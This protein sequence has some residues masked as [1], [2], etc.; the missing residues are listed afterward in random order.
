MKNYHI[1]DIT[2]LNMGLSEFSFYLFG[3]GLG[4]VIG[5]NSGIKEVIHRFNTYKKKLATEK[6]KTNNY[7]KFINL[8]GLEE[9]YKFFSQNDNIIDNNNDSVI[10]YRL[11][12]KT[13]NNDKNL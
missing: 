1:L 12:N 2:Q 5:K 13:T 9:E 6:E 10:D 3:F 11:N 8:K 7:H 4:Y